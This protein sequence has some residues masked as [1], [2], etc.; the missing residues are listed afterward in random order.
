[1]ES[2]QEYIDMFLPRNANV[3]KIMDEKMI[4]KNWNV[5]VCFSDSTAFK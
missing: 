3:I 2:F 1:M 4:S 5:I